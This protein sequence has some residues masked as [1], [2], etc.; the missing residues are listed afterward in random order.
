MKKL[1]CTMAGT[2]AL[3][4]LTLGAGGLH[5]Q[6]VNLVTL[7]ATLNVQGGYSN[8]GNTL[9]VANPVKMTLGNKQLL[10]LLAAAEYYNGNYSYASFPA[11]AKL[12]MAQGYSSYGAAYV[13]FAVWS[14]S[15]SFLVDVSDVLTGMAGSYDNS[16]SGSGLNSVIWGKLNTSTFVYQPTFT[17]EY[18]LSIQYDDTGFG[19]DL[20]FYAVGLNVDANTDTKPN[21]GGHYTETES[22]KVA[23]LQGFG[24]LDGSPLFVTGN[25]TGSAKTAY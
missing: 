4:C 22:Q 14:A 10:P 5:A 11:G 20:K 18:P 8:S 12:V 6:V 23:T 13:D 7:S 17:R 19:G 9:N 2:V 16:I 21:A 24:S 3:A 15:N 25:L 1:K